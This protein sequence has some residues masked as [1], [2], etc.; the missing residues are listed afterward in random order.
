MT[1]S[2]EHPNGP[3][4]VA[5]VF[6]VPALRRFRPALVGSSLG[7]WLGLL[8]LVALAATLTDG[9]YT[10]INLA[11]AGVLALRLVPAVLLG[12]A[13]AA[14]TDRLNGRLVLVSADLLR[15]LLFVS[16]P[17]IGKLTWLY[18]AALLIEG[19]A[20]ASAR[21]KQTSIPALVPGHRTQEALRAG[22]GVI[23]GAAPVAALAFALLSL[24]NGV[25]ATAADRFGDRPI[26]LMLY[27]TALTF[28]FS[29]LAAARV[30]IPRPE[31]GDLPARTSVIG[32]IAA[33]RGSVTSTPALRGLVTGM[34]GAFAAAGAV[35]GLAQTYAR[36]LGAGQPGFGVLFA[37]VFIGLALGLRIGPQL[38][39]GL[40]RFRLFGLSLIA[41][42][43]SLAALALIPNM[44]MA[45]LLAGVLGV[46]GGTAWAGGQALLDLAAD[47]G[48]RRRT[49]AYLTSATQIV[50]LVVLAAGPALAAM[51]GRHTVNFTDTRALSYN[52]AAFVFLIAA[53]L[54][55][56][57]GITTYRQLDDQA[58]TSLRHDLRARWAGRRPAAV[59]RPRAGY[60][61]VFVALEGGDGSGKSTQARLLAEWLRSD[62]GHDVV[63]TREPGATPLGVRLREVLLGTGAQLG[64]RP[65]ALLFAADRAHHVEA[66]VRPALA[67]GAVVVTDRYIDSSVAYQ[68]AGR[69][70]DG[71]EVRRISEWATEGLE[72]A[73]TVLLDVDPM[74]SKA[75]RAHDL[76]RGGEDRLE[77]E[78][79][80]F[81]ERV[82]A[83]FLAQARSAPHRY[84]VI[85]AG[86]SAE[87]VQQ[88]I[89]EGV[90][91]VLPVSA[92]RR[93]E[94]DERLA[95]EDQTRERR[96]RA[97][98]EVLR[99]D[100]DLRRRR[101]EEAREREESRRRARDEAERQLQQEA[102][103]ELRA[104]EMQRNREEVDRRAAAAAAAA[105]LGPVTEPV[106]MPSRRTAH[107]G[108][109]GQV[110]QGA[111]AQPVVQPESGP[112]QQPGPSQQASPGQPGQFQQPGQAGPDQARPND[113]RQ[114]GGAPQP[115]HV[116]PGQVPQHGQPH[117]GQFRQAGQGQ[118]SAAPP[119]ARSQQPSQQFG[120]PDE[121][122]APQR[123][124]SA[125]WAA[126]EQAEHDPWAAPEAAEP[127]RPVPP[128]PPAA[129]VPPAHQ[130]TAYPAPHPAEPPYEGATTPVPN[131]PL[132][133]Q[134]P[135]TE[136]REQ[137]LP[138]TPAPTPARATPP[139]TAQMPEVADVTALEFD[140]DR[141]IN[142]SDGE[143]TTDTGGNPVRRR[144]RRQA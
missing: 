82:R 94:L 136:R 68:G 9:S 60:P 127:T 96:A 99:M 81:H 92:R 72:P 47:G 80:T 49:S 61:G 14:V 121:L 34:L 17:V 85:D 83:Q 123:S 18:V 59:S 93:A 97:E 12:P 31:T 119:P 122:T 131:R 142:L 118:H 26:D 35:L 2:G 48:T 54:T 25:L 78:S 20:L 75:R 33:G 104:Q 88:L 109:P 130:P 126:P 108:E 67:R 7:E 29:A 124:R 141:T 37:A 134:L 69:D 55:L 64:S 36:D 70:L 4:D 98:A 77:S 105:A 90:R 132:R 43:I 128:V 27:V 28:V 120:Q 58:G 129:Q 84:L 51:I 115:G 19:L 112:F 144:G 139:P 114:P 133:P 8:A 24:I 116:Q 46:C 102:E 22:R 87:E 41:A 117:P 111:D 65:E 100:A 45:V 39:D 1:A 16:I 13:V 71:D 95:E 56:A 86:L 103:R 52:G 113:F 107:S 23:Y 74:V 30:A 101:V 3:D 91:Q 137:E 73:L 62:Q 66:V 63:L 50:L 21:A 57:L 106:Q 10:Q 110:E 5:P 32:A 140:Q 138:P 89:R 44:V 6:Q 42:G 79:D 11:V 125:E 135:E 40:S 76:T 15:A 38:L 53:L 143:T